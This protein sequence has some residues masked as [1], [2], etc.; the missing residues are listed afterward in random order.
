MPA[1]RKPK[2]PA[3]P[4]KPPA[5]PPPSGSEQEL[6]SRAAEHLP[7][8]NPG[9]STL[10]RPHDGHQSKRLERQQLDVGHAAIMESRRIGQELH[11]GLG[12]VLTGLSLIAGN[13]QEKLRE[14]GNSEAEMAVRLTDGLKQALEQVRGL[15]RGLV[16]VAADKQGLMSALTALAQRVSGVQGIVC[17][18]TCVQPVPID[19]NTLATHLYRIA[20][21]AVT[22]AM[23]HG[24][25][26]HID[27]EL[28][29]IDGTTCLHVRDDGIGVDSDRLERTGGMGVQIMRHRADLINAE[30][31][32]ERAPSGGT[33]VSVGFP[34]RP[35]Q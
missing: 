15:A 17:T 4:K 25:A 22:N 16:P 11:D 21:E 28:A 27:I 35:K 7:A 14:Q 29:P 23:R 30:L 3:V 20:Q 6:P 10:E 34:C 24:H 33:Q 2:R 12:Q 5:A 18:F 8:T 19:D 31:R 13:L 26:R 32:I 9:W 1:K